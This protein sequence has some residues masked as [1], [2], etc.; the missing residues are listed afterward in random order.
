MLPADLKNPDDYDQDNYEADE[1]A[2]GAL[3]EEDNQAQTVNKQGGRQR[4]QSRQA[5]GSGIPRMSNL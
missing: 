5:A 3:E 1:G 4:A 2:L